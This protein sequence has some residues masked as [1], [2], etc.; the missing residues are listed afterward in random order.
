MNSTRQYVNINVVNSS[1]ADIQATYSDTRTSPILDDCSQWRLS[2]C[3]F[4]LPT[5]SSIPVLIVRTKLGQSDPT[6]KNCSVSILDPAGTLHSQPVYWTPENATFATPAAPLTTQDMSNPNYYFCFSIAHWLDCINTAFNTLCT[7]L[8]IA[9]PP[10]FLYVGGGS[11]E[12]HAD[13]ATFSQDVSGGY[14]I[15]F[16]Q[17]LATLFPGFYTR[18]DKNGTQ[19]IIRPWLDGQNISSSDEVIMTSDSP[20]SLISWSPLKS[21]VFTSQTMPVNSEA[22]STPAAFN[23]L[24]STNASSSAT[25]SI[26]TD[27][28]CPLT[29]GLEYHGG[30]WYAPNELRLVDLMSKIISP[31]NRCPGILAN[32]QRIAFSHYDPPQSESVSEARFHQ[33]RNINLCASHKNISSAVYSNDVSRT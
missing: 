8:E 1:A 33:K 24:N 17:A 5:T 11:F 6:M 28:E 23:S 18:V 22:V 27:M 9:N 14:R 25:A 15:Y 30:V 4:S 3:R 7:S 12:L 31:I 29:N 21:L 19:Y 32:A 10:Y 2:I 13:E 26:I 16:N 20:T